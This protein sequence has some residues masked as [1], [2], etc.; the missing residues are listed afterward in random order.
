MRIFFAVPRSA[1]VDL[2]LRR[3]LEDMGHELVRF[4]FPGWPDDGDVSWRQHG[5]PRTNQRLLE[6]FRSAGRVDLFFGYFYASV[7]YPET[8]DE[9]RRSGVPT[10]N[11]SCNNVHQFDLVRDIAAHFDVCVVPEQAAQADF[12][13]VGARPIRIQLAANPRVYHPLAEPR[14]YDVTFVGQ[15][16]ADRAELLQHLY[17]N[18][19]AVRAWGAGW[20]AR[21][22]LDVAQVK[23]G[24]ALIEDE[25][26][27][28]VQRLVRKR[29]AGVAGGSKRDVDTRV[30]ED[31][32]DGGLETPIRA[33]APSPID[34]SRFGGPRLLQRDL[35]RMFSQSRLSLG[36]AT[37][38]DSHLATRRLR[39]LRLREFEAPMSGAL[40]LTEDQP[41][42]AEYF[43][44]GRELLTYADRDDLLEQARFY[45]AHQELAER[46]RR[47]GLERARREHTWQHRFAE[48]FL[49]LGLKIS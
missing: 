3:S 11:F 33:R 7:V 43:T 24:L 20:Q 23:A 44:P 47:A 5:K 36:F 8:L 46:I 1:W 26:W 17:A 28:G 21:K 13:S 39:H 4:D 40:Y 15:Q 34:T 6:T 41:E 45:L 30:K 14:L 48:L 9:I 22:R 25:R 19:V 31:G 35:V 42:L 37:A 2:N 32:E 38:G 49:I 16:Y 18:G 29:V 10:V 12:V 27:D